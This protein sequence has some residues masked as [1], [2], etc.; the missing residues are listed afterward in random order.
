MSY[1]HRRKKVERAWWREEGSRIRADT[2][3]VE[4][5]GTGRAA[6]GGIGQCQ[7]MRVGPKAG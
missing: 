5:E 6:E 1:L 7:T 3:L 2:C 4:R